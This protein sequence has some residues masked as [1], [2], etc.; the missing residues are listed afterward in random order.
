M[1]KCLECE[2]CEHGR[3]CSITCYYLNKKLKNET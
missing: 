1:A 2:K 3:Y